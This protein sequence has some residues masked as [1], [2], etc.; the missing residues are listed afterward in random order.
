MCSN[1]RFFLSSTATNQRTGFR[2]SEESTEAFGQVQRNHRNQGANQA[3]SNVFE[4]KAASSH[5]K[6]SRVRTVQARGVTDPE[7]R[8]L[9]QAL[10]QQRKWRNSLDNKTH[11]DN[12]TN[13]LK[14]MSN[15][16]S[17]NELGKVWDNENDDKR[18]RITA[19]PHEG[20]YEARQNRYSYY[21]Y[22]TL[23]IQ[24]SSFFLVKHKLRVS[25][26][27]FLF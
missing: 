24:N 23:N 20:R 4:Y 26:S 15:R 9:D 1:S 18:H 8:N 3:E 19:N 17:D 6:H 7:A 12:I 5:Q 16:D 21:C 25:G 10:E 22:R 14:N 13:R 27:Y 11:S 2:T